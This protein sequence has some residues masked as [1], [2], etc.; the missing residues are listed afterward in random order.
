MLG[1]KNIDVLGHFG[2]FITG[3]L[4]GFWVLP[5]LEESQQKKDRAVKMS[6]WFKISTVVFFALMFI[7]FFTVRTPVNKFTTDFKIDAALDPAK[8]NLKSGA[9]P[10]PGGLAQTHAKPVDSTHPGLTL[11]QLGDSNDGSDFYDHSFW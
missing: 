3:I 11:A 4:V 2:G 1:S 8:K 9:L 10:S 6:F 5:C 7:L